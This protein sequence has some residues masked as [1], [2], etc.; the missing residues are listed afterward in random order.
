MLVESSCGAALAFAYS[1][2]ALADLVPGDG[3]IV[4]VVCG[5]NLVNLDQIAQWRVNY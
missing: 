2:T 3:A 5:G 1:P 4:V